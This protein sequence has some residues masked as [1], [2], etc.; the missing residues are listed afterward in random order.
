[1]A[2]RCDRELFEQMVAI[3]RDLHQ[4][5]E[6]S[7]HETRTAGKISKMLQE[8]RIP[9]RQGLAGNGIVA[10]LPG[11]PDV[12]AVALRADMD[13]LPIHEETELAFASLQPGCMHAC[14]H[15]G[16]TSMLLGAAALLARD[17]Q[18]P[19]P[20]R[21]IFQ[22]AEELGCGASA[23]VAAGALDGVGI[24]FGGH[25]DRHHAIG[26]VV[27]SDGVVNASTD[28]FRITITGQGGH[29]ARPHESV[30]AVVVGSLL[31][32]AIQTIVSRE[33]NPAYP[34]VVTVGRFEAGTASNVIAGQARLEGTIRSQEPA[35]RQH[36]QRALRRI[37]DA[38]GQLHNAGITLEFLEGTPP[39]VNNPAAA[40]LAREA[41]RQ[42]VGPANVLP[43]RVA[44]MGG[45]DFSCYLEKVP[46]CYVRFGA[47]VPGK[48]SFPA[49]SSKFDFDE[50]VLAVGA[51]YYHAVARIAGECLAQEA[52]RV[53]GKGQPGTRDLSPE[54]SNFARGPLD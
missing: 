16:H 20:V 49:H 3:R 37:A 14:G 18:R 24:I 26:T 21:L 15:D 50:Q 34:S 43:L 1:M 54:A 44:N 51:A 6:L 7:G 13:A 4:H 46:G 40:A 19:A 35:V 9:H 36:L 5:P 42:S 47:Q 22:P 12:P 29:A 39:V 2:L 10:D 33:V 41:A 27:V 11:P 30:D 53:G 25:I 28:T 45:E 31:V 48:E 52:G 17:R 23:M 38:V 8:L 32:M